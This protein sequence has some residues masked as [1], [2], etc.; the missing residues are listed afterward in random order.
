MLA[1]A[2]PDKP[3]I[4]FV[5][6]EGHREHRHIS[7]HDLDCASNQVARVMQIQGVD[8]QSM[9]VVGMW[10]RP[11]HYLATIAA[12]KLGALV[13]PLR[14]EM[15]ANERDQILEL[16]NPRLVVSDWDN[17]PYPNISPDDMLRRAQQQSP[18]ILPDVIPNPGKSIGSGGSTG[19]SKIIVD[20]TPWA[21][22]PGEIELGGADIGFR[23]EQV[24]LVAG[25]LYHNSPFTISHLGLF[26][27][28]TLIVMEKFDA[29]TAVDLIEQYQVNF[30]FMAPTMMSRIVKLP[31]VT[32]RD[33][34]SFQGM[35]HSAAPCPPWLKREWMS[36]LGPEKVFEAFGATEAVGA[37][38]IRGDEWLE[39]PGSL[40]KPAGCDMK[41]LDAEGN[42]V[43]SG[44]VGEIFMRPHTDAPTYQ[45]IG[46][47]PA[48]TTDDG[49]ASVGDM[50]WV[51]KEG[52][53]FLAD[54]R[55]D[56]II[57][58]GANVYPAEVEATLTEHPEV[59]DVAVIGVPDDDW[60]KRVH[61]VIQPRDYLAPPSVAELDAHCRERL[62][63]YKVPKSYEFT[64]E[65]PRQPS[66]KIRRTAMVKERE[67]GWTTTM[68]WARDAQEG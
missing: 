51:D 9:V 30:C 7:W 38:V 14:G 26:E 24:H 63:S 46:S 2:H 5:P 22:I 16:G 4:V 60:G 47:A 34:S 25:P 32:T 33:F 49:F 3:A 23:S 27:D 44:D 43:P 53:L 19:R 66:G 56:L 6:K 15:P 62:M 18:E 1:K 45:Y 41:I 67:S 10:N 57:T 37:T 68:V 11:E 17:V 21:R 13:L 54:R 36:L 48:K 42:E 61:A 20:P 58:G 35:Y 28:H 31:G 29:A 52:Y 12:W 8:E 39:H 50:G 55:V 65:L 40:G 59:G 64:A